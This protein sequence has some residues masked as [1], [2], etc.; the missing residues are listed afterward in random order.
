MMSKSLCRLI[1]SVTVLLVCLA[2]SALTGQSERMVKY[3]DELARV[4]RFNGAILVAQGNQV[5]L[6]RAYGFANLRSGR[7][8]T[9]ATAFPVASISKTFMAVA[10]LQL[11]ERG[12]LRL[13]AA[14]VDYLP[15]FP[16]RDV[17]VSHLLSHTSGLP[18]YNAYFDFEAFPGRVFT[19]ADF[20][21]GVRADPKPLRYPPGSNGNYD[22]VNYVVLALLVEHVSGQRFQ[23]YFREHIFAPSGMTRTRYE[24]FCRQTDTGVA[25]GN[26]AY[27]YIRPTRYQDAVRANAVP[28]VRTYWCAYQFSGFGEYVSTLTDLHRYV[29]ALSSHRLLSSATMERLSTPFVLTDGTV[30]PRNFGLGWEIERDTT[31]GRIIGHGGVATGLSSNL[32]YDRITGRTVIV[33]DVVNGTADAISDAAFAMLAG[34]NVPVP[35]RNLVDPYAR[36]LVRQGPIRARQLF[37]RLKADTASYQFSENDINELGYDLIGRPSGYRFPIV[38]RYAEAVAALQ[39]NTE[40]FPKS[41]NAWDSYGEA[42]L[43]AGRREEAVQMYRRALAIDSTFA[44]ARRML[45]S[46]R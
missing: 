35:K 34:R 3:F 45:D 13:D 12:K 11:A 8:L 31:I 36:A 15:D 9:A 27:P 46:L 32:A 26:F 18:P 4:G 42:L 14:V 19:N 1:R 43:K 39:L 10:V 33:F 28:F 44:S 21:P 7:R 5:L 22:N 20:L 23:E 2:P 17:T 6:E 30:N 41:A 40:L 25:H 29:Q 24:T 38:H 16:Y 37:D